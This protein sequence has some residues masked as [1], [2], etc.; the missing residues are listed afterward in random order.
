MT[1]N[2]SDVLF[3]FAGFE[4]RALIRSSS[5]VRAA[6]NQASIDRTMPR[7]GSDRQLVIQKTTNSTEYREVLNPTDAEASRISVDQT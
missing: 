2:F 3:E 7:S 1:H 5:R 6:I 4:R